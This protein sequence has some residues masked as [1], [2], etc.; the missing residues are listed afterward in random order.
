MAFKGHFQPKLF[1]DSLG[2]WLFLWSFRSPW[3]EGPM[4]M[5]ELC[6][7]VSLLQ[8]TQWAQGLLGN[9]L[10]NPCHQGE[11]HQWA[12]WPQPAE[13]HAYKPVQ[14]PDKVLRRLRLGLILIS[15][16]HLKIKQLSQVENLYFKTFFLVGS[17]K[18][19]L[20]SSQDVWDDSPSITCRE[21][22]WYS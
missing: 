9:M 2:R 17:P 19:H 8:G 16:S 13:V 7:A 21:N 22:L 3:E 14:L 6:A 15:F 12:L 4:A 10:P 20:I 11:S 18:K 5:A 1:C